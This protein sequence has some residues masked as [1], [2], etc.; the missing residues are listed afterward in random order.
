MA[1]AQA[2]AMREL[3]GTFGATRAG[4]Y[5]TPT[6]VFNLDQGGYTSTTGTGSVGNKYSFSAERYIGA[7]HIAGEIRPR[8]I[9]LMYCVKY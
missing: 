9:A 3:Y 1:T 8:N 5:N 2:D 6:G 4:G 7:T